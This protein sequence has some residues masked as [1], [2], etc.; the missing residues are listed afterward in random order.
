VFTGEGERM[1]IY[2]RLFGGLGNQL[3]QYSTARALSLRRGVAL[4]LDCRYLHREPAHLGLALHHFAIAGDLNPVGLPPHRSQT[5]AHGL[6]R[7]GIGRPRFL[8]ERTLG[9]NPAVMNAPDDTYLH[10]YFQSESYFAD[11]MGKLREELSIITP[12][13]AENGEWLARIADDAHSVSVHLRR[14]DYVTVSKG[15]ATH[16]TCDEAYYRAALSEIAARTGHTPRAYVFS[17]DP[18]WAE[19]HLSLGVEKVVIGHNGPQQHYE[20]LR[21]MAACRNHVIA[22]STFSWWGAWLDATPDKI[23]VAPKRWFA[24]DN[25]VNPDIL[26]RDWLVL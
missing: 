24:T 21:L 6:W 25:L 16:G 5:L 15:N 19:A 9:V 22:N 14:G 13:S 2:A 8:R 1:M 11:A 18:A 20:D 3:F 4:G 12:P 17:D 10:G 23:V 7:F 26:P